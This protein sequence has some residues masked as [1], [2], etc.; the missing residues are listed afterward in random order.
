MIQTKGSTESTQFWNPEFQILESLY[1]FLRQSSICRLLS[2]HTQ[3]M[4]LAALAIDQNRH[5]L[6][7]LMS[8]WIQGCH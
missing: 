7:P 1:L 2:L 4:A 5:A 6:F 3:P 8:T